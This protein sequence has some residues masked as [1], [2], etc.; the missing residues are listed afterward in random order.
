[1]DTGGVR[2]GDGTSAA[3][4]IQVESS[5]DEQEELQAYCEMR[6]VRVALDEEDEKV[7]EEE[8]EQNE[9]EEKDEEEEDKVGGPLRE[10]GAPW[11][12]FLGVVIQYRDLKCSKNAA[13]KWLDLASSRCR[14]CGGGRVLQVRCCGQW[15]A[16]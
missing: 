5:A 8:K 11:G 13:H 14:D 10:D 15:F 12:Q 7:Q 9:K 16:V 1:M 3:D 6:E 4:A 2:V